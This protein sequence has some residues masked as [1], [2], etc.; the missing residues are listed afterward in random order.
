M[1]CLP[2][3]SLLEG[4][5]LV[6]GEHT[7]SLFVLPSW[8]QPH[9]NLFDLALRLQSSES[10]Q[11]SFSSSSFSSSHLFPLLL[12]SPNHKAFFPLSYQLLLTSS[13]LVTR[14]WMGVREKEEALPARV[15]LFSI[16]CVFAWVCVCLGGAYVEDRGQDQVS[17]LNG[18][19]ICYLQT[20]TPDIR[21]SLLLRFLSPLPYTTHHWPLQTSVFWLGSVSGTS[22]SELPNHS[23]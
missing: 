19:L 14:A 7:C 23:W 8:P 17:S 16:L 1:P 6:W 13:V 2:L 21:S 10:L 4:A 3:R 22:F 9:W 20:W 15:Y 11:H 18:S 12:S 5:R